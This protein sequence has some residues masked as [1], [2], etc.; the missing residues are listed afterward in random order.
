MSEILSKMF[1]K[2]ASFGTEP[3]SHSMDTVINNIYATYCH[4]NEWHRK[5]QQ[6]DEAFSAAFQNLTEIEDIVLCGLLLGRAHGGF[7]GA[8]MMA[9]GG[10][11]VEAYMLLRGCIEA[12]LYALHVAD[13]STLT[14][15]WLNR[16]DNEKSEAACRTNFSYGAVKRTLK[17]KSERH[18]NIM[19]KLYET[20]IDLGG[21][22]NERAITGNLKLSKDGH[23]DIFQLL[24]VVGDSV[25]MD[26][27][28]KTTAQIGV[29]TLQ[30]FQFAQPAHFK[31]FQIDAIID[32]AMEGL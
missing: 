13:S 18:Y 7:R 14:N 29:C 23:K 24:H 22:P 28:L 20:T 31:M 12:A 3:L 15:I 4:K 9:M 11:T 21:H 6:L 26:H 16:H 27:A 30:I 17:A 19:S 25:Q 1:V 32:E 2:P 10:H 8:C 5:F